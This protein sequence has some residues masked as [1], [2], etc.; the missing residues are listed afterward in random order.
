M[1]WAV[2]GELD[3]NVL[4]GTGTTGVRWSPDLGDTWQLLNTG[5]ETRCVWDITYGAT[6]GQLFAGLRGFG[7]VELTEDQLGISGPTPEMLSISARPNPAN[8]P[9]TLSVLGQGSETVT[10]RVFDTAGR[11]CATLDGYG[12]SPV[13]TPDESTPAGVYLVKAFT[14]NGTAASRVVLLR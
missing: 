2:L 13:W 1:S 4:N 10:V 3:D 11:L 6:P 5:I 12:G 14:A 7:V 8:G 9:V